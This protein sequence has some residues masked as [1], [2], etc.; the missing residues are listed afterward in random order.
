[1]DG[2]SG[3]QGGRSRANNFCYYSNSVTLI[4]SFPPSASLNGFKNEHRPISTAQ[5][6]SSTLPLQHLTLE[7]QSNQVRTAGLVLKDQATPS[8]PQ[9][10]YM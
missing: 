8:L 5:Y 6:K 7:A 3:E 9:L 10:I 1:M 2:V 4:N